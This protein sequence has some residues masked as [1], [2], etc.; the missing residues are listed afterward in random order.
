VHREGVVEKAAV[1]VGLP[2]V[3]QLLEEA[4]EF[5]C[6]KAVVGPEVAPAI[7]FLDVMGQAVGVV[8]TD[9][10]GEEVLGA[11]GV[12]PAHHVGGDTGG[13]AEEGEEDEFVDGLDIGPAVADGDLEVQV[14][15]IDLGK[16]LV[17][18]LLSLEQLHLGI[19]Y[20]V[21]VLLERFAVV[22]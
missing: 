21:Q 12:F 16:G 5:L 3:L 1:P 14:V 20:G 6:L 9:G 22:A 2:G 4:T 15:G 8:E 11:S 18:P 10:P 19:A 13:I 7:G 17:D